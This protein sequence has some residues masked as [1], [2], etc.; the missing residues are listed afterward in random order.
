MVD[1]CS[2]LVEIYRQNFI[3][4]RGRVVN[5]PASHSGGLGFKYRPG[6]R[7]S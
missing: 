7:L 3:E 6:Y 4:R 1:T 2:T 5:T